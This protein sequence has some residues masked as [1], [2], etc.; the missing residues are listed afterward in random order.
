MASGSD[1][2]AE[3]YQRHIDWAMNAFFPIKT[4]RKKS[5]DLP[6]INKAIWKRIKR[7]M[8]VYRKEG[9]SELWKWMKSVTDEIIKKR[10]TH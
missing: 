5:T 6:W 7:R 9:R 2:K 8:R 4:V 3:I 1:L 10:K